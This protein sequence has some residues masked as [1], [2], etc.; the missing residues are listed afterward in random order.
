MKHNKSPTGLSVA[1]WH[2]LQEVCQCCFYWSH[3]WYVVSNAFT[4]V[5]NQTQSDNMIM[6]H[7]IY[8]LPLL[9]VACTRH[10]SVLSSCHL[11]WA[12]EAV[13]VGSVSNNPRPSRTALSKQAVSRWE[14][15]K[16]L[17]KHNTK[18]SSVYSTPSPQ[19]PFAQSWQCHFSGPMATGEYVTG[20]R[21]FSWCHEFIILVQWNTA[22]SGALISLLPEMG[23]GGDLW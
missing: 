9:P 22:L 21:T 20:V 1:I 19:S 17:D 2:L 3:F 11:A 5:L 15:R 14:K 23:G 18:G 8:N 6:S 13:Y 7:W 10:Y 4:S 12:N 16:M